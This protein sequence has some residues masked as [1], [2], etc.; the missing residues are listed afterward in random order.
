MQIIEPA[1]SR[2]HRLSAIRGFAEELGWTPS[3][4]IEL[5]LGVDAA[6]NHLVV[7]HG[8]ENAA[9]L[10]FLDF[11]ARSSDLDGDALRSLLTLS[12]NNLVEWHAFVSGS[13]VRYINNLTDP[14]VDVIQPISRSNITPISD[15]YFDEL[16]RQHRYKRSIVSCDDLLIH[17]ISRWKRILKAD[18]HGLIDNKN[19]SALFNAIIFVRGCEDHIGT[20]KKR[21]TK[22]L[23]E[24]LSGIKTREIDLAAIINDSF[25][26]LEISYNIETL[27]DFENLAVFSTLDKSTAYDLFKD[28][29]RPS[30]SPYEFNFAF[31]SK[32]ALSRIYEK[33]VSV[34]EFD[35]K[36]D[37]QLSFIPTVPVERP[38]TKIGAIYT[39]QFIASFFARYVRDNMTP[40]A[41]RK[42]RS[43]DPAC[44]SGIFLRTLLELQCDPLVPDVTPQTIQNSFASIYGIDRDPNACH[45]TRLSLSLLHLVATGRLPEQI[46]VQIADAVE[47]ALK[48]RLEPHSFDVILANPPYIKLEHLTEEERIIYG[49]YLKE[50]DVGRIDSYI[51]FT[52][53]CLEKVE[54][55][56]FVCLVLPQSFLF[57]DNTRFLRQKVSQQF[58]VRCLVDLSSVQVFEDV[59]VS[60][61]LLIVQRKLRGVSERVKAQIVRCQEFVGASLQ[62]C[63]N[64]KSIDTPYYNVFQVDQAWFSRKEWVVLRPDEMRLTE[65]L[66]TF[67]PLSHFLNVHQGVITG[68]DEIFIRRVSEI[69]TGDRKLYQSYL[70]D[71]QIF[72]YKLPS[73]LEETIFYPFL[74]GVALNHEYI[75]TN[76]PQTWTYLLQHQQRLEARSSVRR[77]YAP[78]WRPVWPRDPKRILRPKIVCPHLMLAPRFAVDTKGTLLVSRSPFLISKSSEEEITFLKFFCAILNSTVVQW[79]ISRHSYK[80][81]RGYHR[82]EVSLL[83]NVPAPNPAAISKQLMNRVISLVDDCIALGPT[84]QKE[85]EIDKIVSDIYE[86]S[87]E[88]K[89]IIYG[90]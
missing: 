89:K 17:T 70:P 61:V 32:H 1:A 19:I 58:D 33:Y 56:G 10:S 13:E 77:G 60:N 12:Y 22:I 38:T 62:A 25:Q 49:Q 43:F 37:G 86:L 28:F 52:K 80:Y 35:E 47:L 8:L 9:V 84:P 50:D 83:K 78:W 31:M 82:I 85:E 54:E 88:E 20:Y 24:L 69:P 68:D 45:A 81:S 90:E 2:E 42:F 76:F 44:G 53:L 75:E 29:Y 65:R 67:L 5:P 55:G 51:A 3:Y 11:P 34:L 41:F 63:L 87:T 39:P 26:A 14:H 23:L 72:R 71:R 27:L 79:Y 30:V 73:R 7:E 46:N 64:G 59:G 48:D 57:A 18:Y 16:W 74:D 4:E 36:S 21:T 15:G 6:K 40:R 66:N